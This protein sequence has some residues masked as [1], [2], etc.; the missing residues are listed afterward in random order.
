M[1]DRRTDPVVGRA[2]CDPFEA[3]PLDPMPFD[4]VP[5]GLVPL[6]PVPWVGVVCG[7]GYGDG[8]EGGW[9]ALAGER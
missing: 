5:F 1:L 4:P 8:K 3:D 2:A 9:L 6:V 7:G